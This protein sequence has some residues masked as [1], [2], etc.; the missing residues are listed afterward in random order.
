MNLTLFPLVLIR[1][2]RRLL[3]RVAWKR[4]GMLESKLYAYMHD[5]GWFVGPGWRFDLDI[6]S[7]RSLTH[8]FS[9]VYIH[10]WLFGR[11]IL[12]VFAWLEDRW[13][14]LMGRLGQY[15]MLIIR[16]GSGGRPLSG[17]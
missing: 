17:S 3:R 5:Y 4:A 11:Q 15:P 10:R 12:K 2:V 6:V 14:R 16:E 8:H 7:W 1:G 9:K 13:P